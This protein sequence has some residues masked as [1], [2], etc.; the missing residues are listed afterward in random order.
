MARSGRTRGRR[1]DGRR[2]LLRRAGRA[3]P[4]RGDHA[5]RADPTLLAP[6]RLELPGHRDVHSGDSRHSLPK[7]PRPLIYLLNHYLVGPFRPLD[8]LGLRL[9]PALFGIL[10]VPVIYLICRRLAVPSSIVRRAARGCKPGARPLLTARP[11]LVAVFL[12]TII[13]PIAVYLGVRER[14]VGCSPSGGDHDPGR[15]LSSGGSGGPGWPGAPPAV[16]TC[17]REQLA[18]VVGAHRP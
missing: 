10:A 4:H 3:A 16:R 2:G 6:R 17:S 18:T 12:F 8:E 1:H 11:L 5:A 14:N 7:N 15:A 13:A 9:L